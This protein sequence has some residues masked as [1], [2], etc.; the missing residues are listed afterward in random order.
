MHDL[1]RSVEIYT[2]L[3]GWKMFHKEFFST[4]L[5]KSVVMS[6]YTTVTAASQA[7]DLKGLRS[8]RTSS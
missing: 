6:V 1:I 7:Y 3:Q 2:N 5:V 8:V 4:D